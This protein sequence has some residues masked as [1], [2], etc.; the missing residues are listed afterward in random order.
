MRHSTTCYK[1]KAKLF[2]IIRPPTCWQFD[3][4]FWFGRTKNERTNNELKWTCKYCGNY[5]YNYFQK[6]IFLKFLVKF[7]LQCVFSLI[8]GN[9]KPLVKQL[10]KRPRQIPPNYIHNNWRALTLLWLFFE[11]FRISWFIW[12]SISDLF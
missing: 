7:L 6:K 2:L 3:F 8:T 9:T 11:A 1:Q 12:Q 4:C 10:V 5:S